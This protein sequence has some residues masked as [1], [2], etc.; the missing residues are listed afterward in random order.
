MRLKGYK[1]GFVL[2]GFKCQKSD[3]RNGINKTTYKH[4][5]IIL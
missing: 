2:T 5:T 3:N 4:L 1:N